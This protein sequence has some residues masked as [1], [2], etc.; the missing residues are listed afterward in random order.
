VIVS[1]VAIAAVVVVVVV[2]VVAVVVV[3][4]VV[5]SVVAVV[6]IIMLL[7]FSF[8]CIGR[9]DCRGRRVVVHLFLVHCFSDCCVFVRLKSFLFVWGVKLL[10]SVS[11]TCR[12]WYSYMCVE[13]V[14]VYKCRAW[15]SYCVTCVSVSVVGH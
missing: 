4:V 8:L 6:A 12:Q 9:R 5:V 11:G 3:V 1:V 14:L 10:S 2:V 7:C 13:S 15:C